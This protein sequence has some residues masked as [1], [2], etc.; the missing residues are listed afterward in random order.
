MKAKI[1]EDSNFGV[2]FQ[3][4]RFQV[5]LAMVTIGHCP[6]FSNIQGE[7]FFSNRSHL[8]YLKEKHKSSFWNSNRNVNLSFVSFKGS[9]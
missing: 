1:V 4:K 2:G 9:S 5:L 7:I 8:H 6:V 3:K